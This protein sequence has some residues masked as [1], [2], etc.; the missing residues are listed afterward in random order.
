MATWDESSAV[1]GGMQGA[2]TG[3]AIGSIVP[4]VGTAI[5]AGA[6][7]LIGGVTGGIFGGKA[8]DAAKE[9]EKRRQEEIKRAIERQ[10]QKTFD[11]KVNAEQWALADIGLGR[12]DQYG[13]ALADRSQFF[14]SVDEN[15]RRAGIAYERFASY[16]ETLQDMKAQGR[17]IGKSRKS[18]LSGYESEY[19]R[20]TRAVDNSTTRLSVNEGLIAALEDPQ[21]TKY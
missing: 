13:E 10:N 17:Y 19:Q 5:G 11:A 15:A 9:A 6:G 8:K 20:A 3:A 18:K 1:S 12:G 7:L 4:G 2:A 16:E 21:I 14:A